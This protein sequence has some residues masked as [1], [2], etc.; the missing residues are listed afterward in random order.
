[1]FVAAHDCYLNWLH[2]SNRSEATAKFNRNLKSWLCGNPDLPDSEI[3][4]LG[5]L[6]S[7]SK[8]FNDYKII[9]WSHGYDPSEQVQQQLFEYIQNG[10]ALFGASTPWGYLQIYPNKTLQD[11]KLHNF[12]KNLGI[13]FTSECLWLPD[14]V[15]VTANRAKHSQFD[16]ALQ[17][18]THNPQKIGKYFNTITC[19]L[20]P[21]NKEGILPNERILQVKDLVIVECQNCGW[22]PVPLA[23]RPVRSQEERNATNLLGRCLHFTDG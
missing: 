13:L 20:E 16:M 7:I 22:N 23:D 18:V 1:V 15:D 17:K 8:P 6:V 2:D 19:G 14:E 3:I 10:G 5:K 4:E 9:K 21:L 12:I 11:M